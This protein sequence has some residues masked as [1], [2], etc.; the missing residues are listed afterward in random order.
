MDRGTPGLATVL[1]QHKPAGGQPPNVLRTLH[2]VQR[3]LGY[4]S[5]E[6][7]RDIAEVLEVTEADVAGVLSYYPDLR[8]ESPSRHV[9]RIC[10]GESCIA[11]HCDRLLR[12]LRE[13]LRIEVGETEPGRRFRLEQVFCMGNCAV[14]PTLAID[15][16]LYGRVTVF[17]LDHL[18]DRYR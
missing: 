13:R 7:I 5:S 16:D 3:L 14:G 1:E 8:R 18:L 4:V 6:A 9:I 17:R 15:D 11:N 12:E 10:I 2:A